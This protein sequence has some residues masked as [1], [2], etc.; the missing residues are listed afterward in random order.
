MKHSKIY[1]PNIINKDS[2][3]PGDLKGSPD[4][5]LHKVFKAKE[6]IINIQVPGMAL[7]GNAGLP[8]HFIFSRINLGGRDERSNCFC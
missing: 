1:K 8:T 7:L 6:T 2:M 3:L 5:S 4:E